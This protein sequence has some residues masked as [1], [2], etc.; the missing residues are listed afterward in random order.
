[1]HDVEPQHEAEHSR[2]QGVEPH[3]CALAAAAA[4][5]EGPYDDVARQPDAEQAAGVAE[6]PG[7]ILAVQSAEEVQR[8]WELGQQIDGVN[9]GTCVA[10]Q[11]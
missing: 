9:G 11:G 1:M 2:R 10:E 7:P 6:R 8:S 5:E 4:A 3:Q